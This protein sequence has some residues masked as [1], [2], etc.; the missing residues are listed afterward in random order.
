MS[1]PSVSLLNK[2]GQAEGN[3]LT[4]TAFSETNEDW[5]ER[6]VSILFLS[7]GKTEVH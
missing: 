3:W 6:R 5:F 2:S 1:G 4:I 7:A